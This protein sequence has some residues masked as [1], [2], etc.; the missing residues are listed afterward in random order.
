[1]MTSLTPSNVIVT[2]YNLM[3]MDGNKGQ[4]ERWT[5]VSMAGNCGMTLTVKQGRRRALFTQT[6]SV[7]GGTSNVVEDVVQP[8]S[9][10]STS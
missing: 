2:N 7:D 1:M 10:V 9:S 4:S 8:A 3:T 5:T 6:H